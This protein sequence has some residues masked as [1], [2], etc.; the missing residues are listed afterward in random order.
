MLRNDRP[1]LI[2][3]E[4]LDGEVDT[5]VLAELNAADYRVFQLDVHGKPM[6]HVAS[7]Q[8]LFAAPNE[9]IDKVMEF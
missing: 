6:L 1:Q 9:S 3:F 4:S 2:M 7:N 5:V 8:N